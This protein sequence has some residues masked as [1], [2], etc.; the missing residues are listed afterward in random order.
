MTLTLYS[1]TCVKYHDVSLGFFGLRGILQYPQQQRSQSTSA[2]HLTQ[3]PSPTSQSHEND[4]G[5]VCL[6]N[7][8][9]CEFSCLFRAVKVIDLSHKMIGAGLDSDWLI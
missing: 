2:L 9:P 8:E 4:K 5:V 3:Y 7:D 1:T 6:F